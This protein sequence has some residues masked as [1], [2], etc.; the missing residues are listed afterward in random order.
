MPAA[1]IRIQSNA[2]R[3]V[4]AKARTA[5]QT[6]I[7]EVHRR[8]KRSMQTRNLG[9]RDRDRTGDPQLGKL[10]VKSRFSL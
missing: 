5:S 6:A 9:A 7:D 1:N 8:L 4:V 2:T 10:S 3:T